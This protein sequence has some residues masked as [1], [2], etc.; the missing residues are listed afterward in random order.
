VCEGVFDLIRVGSE[1]LQ[2]IDGI[3]EANDGG[4]S[5]RAHY[6]LREYDCSLAN[7]RKHHL[8]AR[9]GFRENHDGE[10]IATH[11]EM[12]DTLWH[13]VVGYAKVVGVQGVDHLTLGVVHRDG[14]V[15]KSNADADLRLRRGLLHGGA[16]LGRDGSGWRLACAGADG[17]KD[18]EQGQSTNPDGD[19]VAHG[20]PSAHSVSNSTQREGQ[21]LP[22]NATVPRMVD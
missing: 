20:E 17:G 12:Q 3:V 5:R 19:L 9:T 4:F 8:D 1:L 22:V 13:S 11:V 2:F 10:R 21:A 15:Y 18:A 7:L 6:D 16:G 14:G